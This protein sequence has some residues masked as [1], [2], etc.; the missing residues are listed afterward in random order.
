MGNLK[1]VLFAVDRSILQYKS[2]VD[3][4]YVGIPFYTSVAASGGEADT[5]PV[6]FIDAETAQVQGTSGPPAIAISV[7]SLPPTHRAHQELDGFARDGTSVEW[8]FLTPKEKNVSAGVV[9]ASMVAITD[10]GVCT[11]SAG[12]PRY[13]D[14]GRGHALK[15]STDFYTIERFGGDLTVDVPASPDVRVWPFPAADIAATAYSIVIPRCVRAFPATVSAAGN[16]SGTAAGQFTNDFTV[17]PA[18]VLP[19]WEATA[20]TADNP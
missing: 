6:P 13:A 10:E 4:A 15:I 2:P 5:T 12:E 8:R 16:F 17:N 20:I 1:G 14:M 18:N 9:A 3:D 11:F 19:A 7:A